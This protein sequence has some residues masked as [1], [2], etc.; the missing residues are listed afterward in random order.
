MKKFEKILN[1]I[2][3]IGEIATG[4]VG[5]VLIHRGK[6]PTILVPDQE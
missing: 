5:L 4:V 2:I 6:E 3:A 1:V